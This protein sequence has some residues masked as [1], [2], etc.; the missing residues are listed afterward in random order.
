MVISKA[1]MKARGNRTQCQ[2]CRHPDR[3]WI[4]TLL[5][6][7]VFCS[8]L[9][10]EFGLQERTLRRHD[11]FHS[12]ALP[13][14]D[15]LSILRSI[16]WLNEQSTLLTQNLLRSGAGQKRSKA[17]YKLRM[18]AIRTNLDVLSEYAKLTDVRKHIDPHVTLPRWREVI[19]KFV[20][21]LQDIPQASE[22]LLKVIEDERTKDSPDYVKMN[23]KFNSSIETSVEQLSGA[24][25][26]EDTGE[27]SQ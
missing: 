18:E 15:P 7:G 21:G 12:G 14:V 23:K 2:V 10:E 16:R 13:D 27:N 22:A 19:T 17:I 1:E 3:A 25:N 8:D 5:A 9:A 11:A 26:G 20:N 6:D 24:R 4:E